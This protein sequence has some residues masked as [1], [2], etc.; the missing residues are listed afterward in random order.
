MRYTVEDTMPNQYFKYIIDVPNMLDFHHA[1]K[2][3][4]DTYGYT[5]DLKK[6][7][8]DENVYWSFT[9]NWRD[10]KIYLKSREE[11]SWFQLKHGAPA[12]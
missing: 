10:H 12:E 4:S 5:E 1:R 7:R 11:L 2:W 3:L 8:P 6:D 9:V